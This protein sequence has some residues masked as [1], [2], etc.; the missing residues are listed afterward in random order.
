MAG[1]GDDTNTIMEFWEYLSVSDIR[2]KGP[3]TPLGEKPSPI[4]DPMLKNVSVRAGYTLV[5][6]CLA[7]SFYKMGELPE[8]FAKNLSDTVFTG[9]MDV[10]HVPRSP[11]DK[12]KNSNPCSMNGYRKLF[13]RSFE[14]SVKSRGRNWKNISDY[15]TIPEM[16]ENY[17]FLGKDCEDNDPNAKFGAPKFTGKCSRFLP[18]RDTEDG[19]TKCIP[20]LKWVMG[21][22]DSFGRSDFGWLMKKYSE[23][24]DKDSNSSQVSIQKDMP[25]P[26]P[27]P[28]WDFGLHLIDDIGYLLGPVGCMESDGEKGHLYF[29]LTAGHQNLF[30]VVFGDRTPEKAGTGKNEPVFFDNLESFRNSGMKDPER[31]I[32]CVCCIDRGMSAKEKKDIIGEFS[33]R[34]YLCIFTEKGTDYGETARGE[35]L[36]EYKS[37]VNK[38]ICCVGPEGEYPGKYKVY[39]TLGEF[40]DVRCEKSGTD[41]TFDR[42]NLNSKKPQLGEGFW[43]V[44]EESALAAYLA[45]SKNCRYVTYEGKIDADVIRRRLWAKYCLT[46]GCE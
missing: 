42:T 34:G 10:R 14:E 33:K 36:K 13:V 9:C 18:V 8:D 6:S 40:I 28:R 31:K 29:D 11:A 39:N 30:L 12:L 24:I 3:R 44:P 5:M 21:H 26:G 38:I 2:K 1:T 4:D 7:P 15:T 43:A 41:W 17:Y 37:F 25:N 20:F 19:V 45:G 16:V 27:Y 22:P 23:F 46:G 32:H 35:L